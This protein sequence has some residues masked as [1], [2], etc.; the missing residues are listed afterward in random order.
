M[1][2]TS[3]RPRLIPQPTLMVVG[4]FVVFW[5]LSNI[6][7]NNIVL[8]Q[9]TASRQALMAPYE[10]RV[11]SVDDQ[12]SQRMAGMTETI[13]SG[14][15]PW[16][17]Q[18]IDRP[19]DESSR[20]LTVDVE[21]LVL[22]AMKCSPRVLALSM[23]PEIRKTDIT[24]AQAAFDP[25]AFLES[26]FIRTSDPV[27]NILTTGPDSSRF[28]DQNWT[29]NS[30]IRRKTALGG[31]FEASQRF[32]FEDNNSIYYVPLPQGTA[33]LSLSYTQPLLNGAGIAYNESVI[34]LAEID[35]CAAS[36]QFAAELQ[37]HLLDVNRAYWT[38]Y[39]ERVTYLLKR[40]LLREA[41]MILRDLNA[42]KTL[43]ASSGQIL[44]AK[45]AVGIE[46]CIRDSLRGC[47]TQRRSQNQSARERSATALART[48]R[49][50]SHAAPAFAI[51]Q[52]KSARFADRR[53]SQSA[54][55]ERV[56]AGDQS[57]LRPRKYRHQG[58]A[59]RIRRRFEHVCQWAARRR[60]DG[61]GLGRSV[62]RGRTWIY[63]R[64]AVR[65]A[66]GK[67]RGQSP[68]YEAANRDAAVLLAVE[69]D[70]G[71]SRRGNRKSR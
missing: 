34:V 45:S 33:K 43:D 12:H 18:F 3:T 35:A 4:L 41:E 14:F 20:A 30:G 9:E 42:R 58:S 67:P 70:C 60:L 46:I 62:Q 7:D 39:L 61:P 11:A 2:T 56:A 13:P 23:V 24:E 25:K 63:G 50:D 26:K 64:I 47:H 68:A 21:A 15:Q 49:I 52:R 54:R 37:N 66:A 59:A 51:S 22:G 8:A 27:G 6:S 10:Q 19:L 48:R 28:R 44:R 1:P 40:R 69:R 17:N 32:G 29:Y 65:V 55:G 5:M 71:Q 31:Q 36:D 53:A 57:G 38:L 16:W